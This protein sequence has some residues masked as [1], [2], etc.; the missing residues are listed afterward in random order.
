M[1]SNGYL[2]KILKKGGKFIPSRGVPL[3][4][5][6]FKVWFTEPSLSRI[7]SI[8]GKL[9]V[10]IVPEYTQLGSISVT[11]SVV[12]SLTSVVDSLSSHLERTEITDI[13]N[14]TSKEIENYAAKKSVDSASDP[15]IDHQLDTHIYW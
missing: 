5:N 1:D 6:R 12:D 13:N 8:G 2:K 14:E 11:Q 3:L 4:E 9:D 7:D 15:R 10:Y